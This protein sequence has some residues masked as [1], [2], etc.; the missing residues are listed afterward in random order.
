[1]YLVFVTLS[2]VGGYS[3]AV[4]KMGQDE[5]RS[6]QRST[7]IFRAVTEPAADIICRAARVL[8]ASTD[9]RAALTNLDRFVPSVMALLDRS[10]LSWSV[11][12]NHASD[13]HDDRI[14]SGYPRD[15]SRAG[16]RIYELTSYRPWSPPVGRA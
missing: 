15:S 11:P 7:V 1:M 12:V 5:P 9:A 10:T 3:V 16:H 6:D 2:E 13:R 8:L 14:R 4:A